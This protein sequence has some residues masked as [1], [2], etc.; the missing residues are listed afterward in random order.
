MS[1]VIVASTAALLGTSDTSVSILY[2]FRREGIEGGQVALNVD[3]P[4]ATFFVNVTAT[5]LGP[6]GVVSTDQA[7]ALLSGTIEASDLN[8]GAAKPLLAVKVSTSKQLA[9]VETRVADT[10]TSQIDLPFSGNCT[11]PR[12]GAACTARLAIDVRRVDDGEAGG[13]VTFTWVL[14]VEGTGRRRSDES[15]DTRVGP[16][17]PPWTVEVTAP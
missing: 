9:G 5:D 4:S 11:D 2:D 7:L 13:N 8:D 12:T 15:E 16:F 3:R 14:D 17:D 6:D 10:F 1:A